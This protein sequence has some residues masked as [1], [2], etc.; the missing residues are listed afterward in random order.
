MRRNGH[1][2]TSGVKFDL[3]ARFPIWQKILESGP[4]FHVFLANFLLRM[5]RN[6]QNS[7]SGQIFYPKFEILIG[8]F[9]FEYK[10]WWASSKIY[11]CFE[12][13]TAFVMQN[14]QNLGVS[15]KWGEFF[16]ETPKRH[17]LGDFMRFEPLCVQIRSV[18]E[19]LYFIHNNNNN[20]TIY[21][22]P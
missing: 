7:T 19:R 2:T 17:I 5:R 18:T 3:R 4:R 13:K 12:R 20:T 21:K 1:K 22:A 8:C 16:D 11:T 15:G 10:F 14:F 9:V 6:G